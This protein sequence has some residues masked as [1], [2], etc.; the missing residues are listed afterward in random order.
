MAGRRRERSWWRAGTM[1]KW[2][3]EMVKRGV[4]EDVVGEGFG[5]D[6]EEFGSNDAEG[7]DAVAVAVAV[8]VANA[9]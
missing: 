2:A 7:G 6:G 1:S 4:L 9:D 3:G 5:D 8:A